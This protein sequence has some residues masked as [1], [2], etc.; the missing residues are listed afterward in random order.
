MH[1][2]RVAFIGLRRVTCLVG[3]HRLSFS[4]PAAVALSAASLRTQGRYASSKN[5]YAVLAIKEGADKAEI[6]KAYRILARKHHPDAPGGSD[7]KFREV[8]EAYEQIKSGVWIRKDQDSS[9][10]DGGGGNANRYSGFRYTTRTHHRSKVSYDQFYEEMH[11]GR[12]K[13]DPFADDVDEAE[14]PAAKDP[15]RNPFAMNEIAFQAWLRFIIMW[16]V[17]FCSLRLVLF[18]LFPPKWEKPPRKPP[19]RELRGRKPPPPKPLGRTE[20]VIVA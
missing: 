16:C 6:K 14:N 12:V 4:D 8:Q 3:G 1:V 20:D 2:S 13:K 5:P 18:L 10:G 7:E 17:V 11:T 15:R 19:P 9:G